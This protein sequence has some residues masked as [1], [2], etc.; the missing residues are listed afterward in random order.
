MADFRIEPNNNTDNIYMQENE[1]NTPLLRSLIRRYNIP[2]DDFRDNFYRFGRML[3]YIR[4][5]NETRDRN[6]IVNDFL[7]S[8]MLNSYDGIFRD[9][10]RNEGNLIASV[11]LFHIIQ[12]YYHADDLI[13]ISD[14]ASDDLKID[15]LN[16]FMEGVN[17]REPRIYV[18]R[19]NE[20]NNIDERIEYLRNR[21]PYSI[22]IRSTHTQEVCE[23]FDIYQDDVFAY[24]EMF[25]GYAYQYISDFR[26]SNFLDIFWEVWNEEHASGQI[27]SAA[28]TLLTIFKMYI[29]IRELVNI[30]YDRVEYTDSAEMIDFFNNQTRTIPEAN[31]SPYVMTAEQ[32]NTIAQNFA[33]EFRDHVQLRGELVTNE[34]QGVPANDPRNNLPIAAIYDLFQVNQAHAFLFDEIFSQHDYN[35]FEALY[36]NS[37]YLGLCDLWY[38]QYENENIEESAR[39]LKDILKFYN[40]LRLLISFH[41]TNVPIDIAQTI[42]DG[43]LELTPGDIDPL[44]NEEAAHIAGILVARFPGFLTVQPPQVIELDHNSNNNNNDNEIPPPPQLERQHAQVIQLDENSNNNNDNNTT[45]YP[46]F[47]PDMSVITSAI[48]EIKSGAKEI[49][50]DISDGTGGR[51]WEVHDM[52]D[53]IDKSEYVK[54]LIHI[55]ENL[56]RVRGIEFEELITNHV[57]E[58]RIPFLRNSNR[59]ISFGNLDIKAMI[60]SYMYFFLKKYFNSEKGKSQEVDEEYWT[61]LLERTFQRIIYDQCGF[62]ETLKIIIF[63]TLMIVS[64]CDEIIIEE[65]IKDFINESMSGYLDYDEF[66]YNNSG[67]I[68]GRRKLTS[69]EIRQQKVSGRAISCTKG[70]K[71]RILFSLANVAQGLYAT[72]GNPDYRFLRPICLVFGYDVSANKNFVND[73]NMAIQIIGQINAM[74]NPSFLTLIQEWTTIEQA[75]E[76]NEEAARNSVRDYIFRIIVP[77]RDELTP[78]QQSRIKTAISQKVSSLVPDVRNLMGGGKRKKKSKISMKNKSSKTRK[79][80]RKRKAKKRKI[81]MKKK[82]TKSR[83]K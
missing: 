50:S 45:L 81:S 13:K 41:N 21:F 36:N 55:L 19:V 40:N 75:E 25:F 83:K 26:N 42:L 17:F 22:I 5:D 15:I 38:S 6:D 56:G 30:A 1:V 57:F 64:L 82:R 66:L 29:N 14:N 61:G 24:E 72:T 12:L 71:E 54:A 62:S 7:E 47:R 37:I 16:N 76:L 23:L 33:N 65:Y 69:E 2:R 27:E 10:L 59:A 53:K 9:V 31:Q 67:Q 20:N 78:Q 80:T 32:R 8:D 60:Y 11:L 70:I 74:D 77:N 52:F 46:V 44:I 49:D 39:I 73:T 35:Y 48:M 51:A 18:V 34:N 43:F 79:I 63:L 68:I 3:R 4:H 58:P 28:S